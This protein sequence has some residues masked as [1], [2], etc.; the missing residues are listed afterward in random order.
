MLMPT[1]IGL[2]IDVLVLLQSLANINLN[3]LPLGFHTSLLA[4][5]DDVLPWIVQAA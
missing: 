3:Y 4:T 5:L 1:A 2:V